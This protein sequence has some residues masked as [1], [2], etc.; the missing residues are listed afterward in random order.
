M[1]TVCNVVN[2][3]TIDKDCGS[4]LSSLVY[5]DFHIDKLPGLCGGTHSVT[6]K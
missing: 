1:M 5:Y 3:V 4:V 6:S 2:M